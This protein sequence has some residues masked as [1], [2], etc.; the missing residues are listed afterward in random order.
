MTTRWTQPEFCSYKN[1][2][3]TFPLLLVSPFFLPVDQLLI[4][5]LLRPPLTP[6]PTHTYTAR[7]HTHTDVSEPLIL[8]L[9]NNLTGG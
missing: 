2:K 1:V 6:K 9:L 5:T 4:I 7:M 3:Y 8:L